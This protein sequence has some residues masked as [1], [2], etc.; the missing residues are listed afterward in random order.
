M[1]A[2]RLAHGSLF[3]DVL[4]VPSDCDRQVWVYIVQRHG[5]PDILAMGTCPTE[6]GARE[7]AQKIMKEMQETKET[8]A[9]AAS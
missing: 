4:R 2:T 7:L 1:S 8:D 3:A 6:K 9:A 5:S